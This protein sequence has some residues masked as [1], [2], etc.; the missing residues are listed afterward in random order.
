MP[1]CVGLPGGGRSAAGLQLARPRLG[2]RLVGD[3]QDHQRDGPLPAVRYGGQGDPVA[4]P[5][6]DVVRVVEALAVAGLLD[7]VE[8]RLAEVVTASELLLDRRE[9]AQDLERLDLL[10]GRRVEVDADV[11]DRVRGHGG[12][13]RAAARHQLHD[14]VGTDPDGGHHRDGCRGDQARAATAAAAG[15]L[16]GVGGAASWLEVLGLGLARDVHGH[17]GSPWWLPLWMPCA[18][19]SATRSKPSRDE[20]SARRL[21]RR[22][23]ARGSDPSAPRRG[24]W[25]ARP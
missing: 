21:R 7:L 23:T 16:A 3:L 17:G 10:R 25:S 14:A 22:R 9:L 1:A 18:G 11:A 6:L 13:R 19:T 8:D 15:R 4:D 5:G 12:R 20:T 2:L 24:S